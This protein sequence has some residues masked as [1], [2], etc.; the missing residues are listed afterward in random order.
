M[1]II[2]NIYSAVTYTRHL[3]SGYLSLKAALRGRFHF[4]DKESEAK[5]GYVNFLKPHDKLLNH[6]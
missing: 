6:N 3:S 1:M 5:K 4:P 2:V